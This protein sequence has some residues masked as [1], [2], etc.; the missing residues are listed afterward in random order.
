MPQCP[1][2]QSEMKLVPAGISKKN[3]KPYNSFYSCPNRC[4]KSNSPYTNQNAPQ[5]Q[6]ERKVDTSSRNFYAE[7]FGKCKY[8]FLIEAYKK[9]IDPDVAETD[10]EDWAMRSM[11]KLGNTELVNYGKGDELNNIPF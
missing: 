9:G 8:G 4:P 10:A 7:N 2:C 3:N 5:G 1:V 11:R 6:I